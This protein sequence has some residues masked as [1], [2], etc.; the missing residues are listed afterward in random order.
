M[1]KLRIG[2]IITLILAV[3]FI[4]GGMYTGLF[5][6]FL[7]KSVPAYLS[8]TDSDVFVDSGNGW[9]KAVNEMELSVN[10]KIKTGSGTAN[11]ILYESVIISLEKNTEVSVADLAKDNLAVK[12]KEG[13]TW[14]KFT[15][16][17]GIKNY[18]ISTPT[19]VASVRGTSFAV[20]H[21]NGESVVFVGEGTVEVKELT[22]DPAN[23]ENGSEDTDESSTSK[24]GKKLTLSAGEKAVNPKDGEL[25]K[26]ELSED[27]KA[28]ILEKMKEILNT[29][30]DVRSKEIQK[31]EKP[32]N[33]IKSTYELSDADVKEKLAE[34]DSGELD[35]EELIE[36]SPIQFEAMN[37]LK[38]MNDEIKNQQTLIAN[39]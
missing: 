34:I 23:D 25:R 35:D 39:S 11:I 33:F 12:L 1:T 24:T 38:G 5:G 27:E 16:L 19:T 20:N 31:H 8:T 9:E 37:K 7:D 14:N 13:S 30:K 32:L 10:D 28:Y 17:S 26:A 21:K 22:K 2:L 3:L 6:L 18:E 36:K 29:L 4:G 15:G